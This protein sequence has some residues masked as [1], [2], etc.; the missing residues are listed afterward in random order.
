MN[1][2]LWTK[3]ENEMAL[4]RLLSDVGLGYLKVCWRKL[5]KSEVIFSDDVEG[6]F[7]IK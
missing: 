6:A 7:A 4:K 1:I 5:K 3:K 2:S